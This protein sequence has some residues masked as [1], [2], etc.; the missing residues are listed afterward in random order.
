[1]SEALNKVVIITGAATGIGA[2]TSRCLAAAGA[3]VMLA[4]RRGELISELATQIRTVGGVAEWRATDVADRTAVQQLA[5]ATLERFGRI[6][7]LINNA[8]VMSISP[9]ADLQVADWDRMI[10][11]NLKGALYGMAAVL[12]TMQRQKS[13]HIINVA[14]TMGHVPRGGA[15]VYCATKAAVLSIAEAFRQEIGPDIRST[16]I[17]PGAVTSELHAG[18]VDPVLRERMAA[19][20]QGALSAE[21]V[22][23]VIR[24]AIAQP[25]SVNI[26][27]IVLR[28]TAQPY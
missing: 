28:P 22:A 15:A 6:D 9:L 3:Q 12:P 5:A 25:H 20:Y 14:S 19:A 27:E 1:M 23:E 18:I 21:S 10:D 8:G 13:G 26:N 17:T 11:I 16:V 2:A 4:S 7:V 24:Y